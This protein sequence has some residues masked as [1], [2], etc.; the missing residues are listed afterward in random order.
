[1]YVSAQVTW[2]N[3][4]MGHTCLLPVHTLTQTYVLSMGVGTQNHTASC[5]VPDRIFIH[6]ATR[7]RVW[8]VK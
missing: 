3:S 2:Y 4:N 7:G 1:M 8:C 6:A 5:F